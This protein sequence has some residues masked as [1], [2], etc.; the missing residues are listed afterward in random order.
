M[1]R[2]VRVSL[3]AAVTLWLSAGRPADETKA[4]PAA[5]Y[6]RGREQRARGLKEL[7]PAAAEPGESARHGDSARRYFENASRLFAL[8][9]QG[10]AGR[11]KGLP[12]TAVPLP[13]DLE[14]SACARCAQAEMLLRAG[15][16]SAA[17]DAMNA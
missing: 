7:A 1:P 3:L 11:V 5:L 15:K 16:A 6:D 17:Q 13:R 12:P 9:A 4:S 14:W 10:F 8:A 2:F